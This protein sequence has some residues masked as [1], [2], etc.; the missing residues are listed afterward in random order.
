M[1]IT[2]AEAAYQNA[3][4]PIYALIRSGEDFAIK[5]LAVGLLRC[6]T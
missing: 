2:R 3:L 6:G 5:S 1:S 4:A